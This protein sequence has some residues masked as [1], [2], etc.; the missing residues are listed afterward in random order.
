[1]RGFVL[2]EQLFLLD[3]ADCCIEKMKSPQGLNLWL[4][5]E[6]TVC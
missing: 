3:M 2:E 4:D 5:V 6:H 1:M